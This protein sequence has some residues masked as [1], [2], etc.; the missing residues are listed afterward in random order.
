VTADLP[1]EG[2]DADADDRSTWR[3]FIGCSLAVLIA[4]LLAT[5]LVWLAW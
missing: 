5:A 4:A 1:P 3:S 2:P